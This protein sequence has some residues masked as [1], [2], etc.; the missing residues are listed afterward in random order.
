MQLK[1][2]QRKNTQ[3]KAKNKTRYVK[4]NKIKN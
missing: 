4:L 3:K 2:K 1:V